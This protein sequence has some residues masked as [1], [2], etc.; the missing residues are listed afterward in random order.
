VILTALAA[1]LAPPAAASSGHDGRY[2]GFIACDPI[3]GQ[4]AQPLKTDFSLTVAGGK[5]EYQRE[6]LRPTSPGRLGVTE[7]GAGTV[8]SSGELTL[9]GGAGGQTWRYEAT[10][11]GRFEGTRLRL[12]GDQRW[13]LGNRPPHSRPCT[14][15]VSRAD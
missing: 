4:T 15:D 11:R 9:T 13:H 6:V 8:S 10:Y 2:A 1:S 3:P 5:A 12:S 14:I 7:R